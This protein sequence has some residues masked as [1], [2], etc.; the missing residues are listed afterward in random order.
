MELDARVTK[1]R[2]YFECSRGGK[3]PFLLG[4]VDQMVSDGM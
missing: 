2:K 3:E 4:T 1:R